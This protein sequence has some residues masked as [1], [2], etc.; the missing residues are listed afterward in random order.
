MRIALFVV[1]GALCACSPENT[2]TVDPD[3]VDTSQ[4]GAIQGRV[5]SPSGEFWLANASAYVNITDADGI[6]TEVRVA[7]T[8]AEG[9][10]II[11]DLQ[12]GQEYTLYVQY[13]NEVLDTEPV[14][15]DYG[16]TTE[17]EEPNCFD[18]SAVSV[19]LVTG[20]YDDIDLVLEKMGMTNYTLI[21][22]QD[23]QN[24]AA[25]LLDPE[26]LGAFD[27]LFFNGGHAEDGVF[28]G[29][30]KAP[31]IIENLNA[32]VSAGGALYASDWS[33]DVIEAVWP[34][35]ID[36][37]GDDGTPDDAQKGEHELVA[38]TVTDAALAASLGSETI[39][40]SYDLP[41]WPPMLE[42]EGFVSTHL[43]GTVHVR[44]GET[45]TTIPSVPLLVS[46]SAGSGRVG[47]ATFRVAANQDDDTVRVLEYMLKAL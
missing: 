42:V 28:Y 26:A 12:G 19:A 39:N 38:A 37:Y 46:F 7:T 2:L 10:F 45:I 13:A 15:V 33:Y 22:G 36:F 11:E 17:L 27:V 21:D 34:E 44:D 4:T 3:N 32:Y 20:D 31:Q 9:R 41:V 5:C 18:P 35:A 8:D 23:P 43:T 47:F 24:L 6:I 14:W 40:I 16:T 25:F 29:G 1:P 30:P